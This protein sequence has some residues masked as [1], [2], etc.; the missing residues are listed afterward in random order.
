MHI[1]LVFHSHIFSIPCTY[2]PVPFCSIV[3]LHL[4]SCSI[5][6]LPG[7][8]RLSERQETAAPSPR[9]A[10]ILNSRNKIFFLA[11]AHCNNSTS[12]YF[13]FQCISVRKRYVKKLHTGLLPSAPHLV[14]E[15]KLQQDYLPFTQGAFTIIKD[16]H[17]R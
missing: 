7:S 9:A 8:F 14:G 11:A 10:R 13:D 12:P 6:F 15:I 1:P 2:H 5:F 4:P 16:S 3:L 17:D